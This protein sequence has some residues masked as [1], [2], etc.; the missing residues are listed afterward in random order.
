M[1]I[2]ALLSIGLLLAAAPRQSDVSPATRSALLRTSGAFFALSVDDLDASAAWY[3]EKLGLAV[4]LRSP[5]GSDPAVVVLEGGGL[6]VELV[7]H[8]D[9]RSAPGTS[10]GAER[11]LVHGYFKAGAIV[12][13]FDKTV[14]VL[15]ARGV[16]I[17]FGPFPPQAD[18]RA[19]VIVRDNAG[20]LIQLFGAR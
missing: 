3:A 7:H 18:Q 10:S 15:R 14:H 16:E 4:V 13:D 12:A 2:F 8:R 19:N 1:K 6:I 11:D 9:A 20:N 5:P 17:A